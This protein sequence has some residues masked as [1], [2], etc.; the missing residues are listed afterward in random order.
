MNNTVA[1][2][3]C[4]CIVIIGGI[5][6][7]LIGKKA[8]DKL[9]N[10]PTMWLDLSQGD[11]S[12]KKYLVIHEFG[13]ALGLLHEHQRS[14]FWKQIKEF[15]NVKKMR[16]D[17]GTGFDLNWGRDEVYSNGDISKSDYDPDS[18]MHYWYS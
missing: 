17:V 11:D 10:D 16:A 9:R 1:I 15:I 5:N 2:D 18:I 8:Q 3:H 7:C 12:Y 6:E 4:S 13:H 14:D